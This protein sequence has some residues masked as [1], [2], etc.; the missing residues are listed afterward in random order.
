MKIKNQ[1]IAVYITGGIASYKAV[2]FI[3]LLIK[4]GAV[5]RVGMTNSATKFITP[6]T[7]ETISRHPVI[8]GFKEAERQGVF[9][10]HI[11]L[12]QWADLSI[13]I[14]ATANIIAKMAN[15]IADD[16]VSSALIA[17]AHKKYV[18]PAMNDVM[19]NN[20]A[21]QRNLHQLQA[22]G[23]Q[24]LEPDNGFLAE[25]YS[26]KGRMPEPET[27]FSWLRNSDNK[28][29]L[30]GVKILITAGGTEEPIDPVRFIGNR[31]SGKMG[32]ALAKEAVQRGADVTLIAG[33]ITVDF[34]QNINLIRINTFNELQ[35][36]LANEFPKC[37]VLIMAAAVSDYHVE[38]S[39][40]YKIK[41]D[42]HDRIQLTLRKNPN[43]LKQL[44]H[45]EHHQ[46]LVGF[47][48]ETDQLLKN[49]T[50][51]LNDKK[52]DMLVANDVSRSDIGFGSNQ[53]AGYFL[54]PHQDPI[55][56]AKCSKQE[57]ARQILNHVVNLVRKERDEN[58]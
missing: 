2:A 43:L 8:V 48:A 34:P 15:G 23:I 40:N 19:W 55:K 52:I 56:V 44:G 21:M 26:G 3:R 45:S 11:E 20:P 29:N 46:V 14:P 49:A 24:I 51:E 28:E 6:L 17:T 54:I 30:S 18:V 35:A 16:F 4:A 10:P 31:S 25:G 37:D 41:A 36:Q 57:F 38:N 58:Q 33:K 39:V 42:K 9:I 22:D 12:A 32:V 7:L 13:V 5:V 1:R 50:E 47:A 53:N 27:V